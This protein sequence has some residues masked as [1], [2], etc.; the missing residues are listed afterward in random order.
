MCT[1]LNKFFLRKDVYYNKNHDIVLFDY[2]LL[3]LTDW[4]R[5]ISQKAYC[6][7]TGLGR[8]NLCLDLQKLDNMRRTYD[9]VTVSKD[10]TI[11]NIYIGAGGS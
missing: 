10:Q 3:L 11:S 8:K 5:D 1:W 4:I 2:C 6:K 7:F 9:M